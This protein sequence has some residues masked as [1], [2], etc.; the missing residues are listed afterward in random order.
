MDSFSASLMKD[1]REIIIAPTIYKFQNFG[2][3]AQEFSLGKRDLVLTNEFI[4]KPFMEQYN[5]ECQYVFQEKFGAGEPSE[6]MITAIFEAIPYDS[7]DRVV[8][9]GGGAIMDLC[10]LLGIKRPSTVNNLYF[11]KDPVV[12][13]KEVIAVPT[14]CGTGSEVTNIS[15]AIVH[16]PSGA[17]TK[18]GLVSDDII[19]N[20]VCL[21]PDLLK[22]LPYK[23]FASSAID[24]LI[25]ATESYLSPAR[26]TMTS[27][28]FSVKAME[29]ILEG[30]RRIGENGPDARLDYL[31]EFVTASLYA[32]IAFLKAGCATVHGMSFPLGGTYHVPHGESNY[33]LF[34][35]ILE[36]YDEYK[37]EGELM[38]FKKLVGRILGC[39]AKDAIPTLNALLEKVL[40]LKPLHEYG[41]KESDIKD[42]PVSVM[43]NQQRL[44]T[45]SYVPMTKELMERIYRECF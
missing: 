16:E 8:A 43:E 12:H 5:L 37:P 18:L 39:D 40:P 3:F 4:Y 32:G 15:V 21:I 41:F 17:T 29:I 45:N 31:E 38:N 7:Y 34:G 20:K 44:I 27:E 35:K 14:T 23:P 24:A 42:F 2:E 28:L 1:K 11:K 26:K 6:E 30:F 25:H 10:K 9:I 13:E 22:T 36:I 19:P 33:A